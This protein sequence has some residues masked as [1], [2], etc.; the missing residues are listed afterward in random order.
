MAIN[1]KQIYEVD[2]RIE[3]IE[4]NDVIEALNSDAYE[5]VEAFEDQ[6]NF[7]IDEVL[8]TFKPRG[9]YKLY[10]PALCTLPPGYTEPAIKLVGTVMIL[11]GKEA[12]TR[13]RKATHCAVLAVNLGSPAEVEALQNRLCYTDFDKELFD[14]CCRV[15]I[16]RAAD[17]LTAEIIKNAVE[18]G[19]YTDE[20]LSPG[21]S[22]FPLEAR[23]K[24]LF[25][26]QA[27]KRIDLRVDKEFNFSSPY[28]IVSIVGLYDRSQK[29]RRRACGRCR[30]RD[31]CSIRAIG[32]TCHGRKGTFK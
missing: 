13:M 18:L 16:E 30:Y 24:L 3:G 5:K 25:Y 23:N 17:V 9:V 1:N 20:R 31:I 21:E 27:D 28:A 11:K 19:L 14:A 6:L 29:G 4:S 8:V 10:N 2:C 15:M 32:M 12:Y 26:I 7:F 22:N